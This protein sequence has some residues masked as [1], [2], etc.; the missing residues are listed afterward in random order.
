MSTSD[1]QSTERTPLLTRPDSASTASSL[2][3]T[4]SNSSDG[5]HER[6]EVASKTS[7][8]EEA[9]LD[10]G[11]PTPSD[12]NKASSASLGRIIAV[13]LIGGFISNADGSLLMATHP[14]IAS[15]FNALHDS[16]WLLTSFAL[17]TAATQPLYGKLSD[18]YG[19]KSL[20]L[21]AYALFALGCFLVGIGK[22]MS[23]LIIGRVISGAGASGMTALVSILITDLV[24][25]RE[26]A[27]WR[28]YINIVATTGRSVGGPLGGWLADTV[29]WRWSFLGQVPFAGLA[30][31]LVWLTLPARV[32]HDE[33]APKRNNFARIDFLGALFMTLTTLS[34]LFP[35]EIGGEKIP[36]NHPVIYA[37][38]GGSVVS[39][40]LFL[41]TEAWYAKE[42]IM[43]LSL[44]RSRDVVA[45]CVVMLAQSAAQIGLMFAIPLYFQITARASNTVAGAHLFPAVVGNAI[46]GIIS[47]MI[48]KR[49]GRYKVLTVAATLIASSGYVLLIVRW[50]GNTNWLE[51]LY[52][53]PGGFGMGVAQ[54][55]LFI[56]IQA[57]I[58]PSHTAV[59]ASTLYLASSVG[60]IGGMAGVNA[61]LQGSLRVALDRGLAGLGISDSKKW[62][63]IEEAASDVNYLDHARPA[64]ASIV[65]SSYIEALT[66]THVLSLTCAL[67]A[68]VGSLF[69]R[70][71]KL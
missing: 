8:D 57:A 4:S 14:V 27:S 9:R 41:S 39:G 20:L 61:V 48:I 49:T 70:Q 19:R 58:D 18:I 65:R 16:S 12:S 1:P 24:P 68:F 7:L 59:A 52:I 44:F 63:V 40:F 64:I 28:S 60:M 35:L 2:S 31:F 34:L 11:L 37:M 54:S 22:S 15:E 17:A 3:L 36:W 56:S 53:T 33:D 42:P 32:H 6:A 23:H 45:S 71:H 47:G 67:T 66:W 21:V 25:L 51:S 10:S 30:I 50:H 69:L 29:G 62:K 55:A 46:G 5:S 43:P 26:V 38:I 13:L